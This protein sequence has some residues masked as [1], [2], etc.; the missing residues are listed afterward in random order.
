MFKSLAAVV[1]LCFLVPSAGMAATPFDAPAVF[2]LTGSSI[3]FSASVET[4][5]LGVRDLALSPNPAPVT[6]YLDID[7]LSS[8]TG[9]F[10][11]AVREVS[12][13]TT[14]T[15]PFD[16]KTFTIA[17]S[18]SGDS[19]S[20]IFL[21]KEDKAV[22]YPDTLVATFTVN[23]IAQS[24]PFT[25]IPLPAAYSDA[26]IRLSAQQSVEEEVYGYEVSVS[27]AI[28]LVG[29][30]DEQAN[31]ESQLWLA[32]QTS[33]DAC[34]SGDTLTLYASAGNPGEDRKLDFY[35][36][37]FDP[38]GNPFLAPEYI[39]RLAA[40]KSS[41]IFDGGAYASPTAVLEVKLPA[42]TPPMVTGGQYE[43]YGALIDSG[44]DNMAS[45][46]ASVQFTFDPDNES[47]E[48]P[49]KQYDGTWTGTGASDVATGDCPALAQV[50]MEIEQHEISGAGD[51]G[52]DGYE[53][54][55]SV[56]DGGEVVDG[57]LLEEFGPNWVP[58]GSFNGT[59]SGDTFS[60]RWLDNYGC[61]GS[62]SLTRFE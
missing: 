17:V 23:G 49:A 19:V 25:G 42:F 5:R 18:I 14:A 59:F 62:V 15:I 6:G 16:D 24:F 20:G 44:T 11:G 35:L 33:K 46:L 3:A 61:H 45:N 26:E 39:D 43:F 21:W 52:E 22:F 40:F 48:V 10:Y 53:L 4:Q 8:K 2:D 56:T 41:A 30:L 37:M 60:G 36:L 50:A 51:D 28:D 13:Q 58:V 57:V 32:L 7:Q 1:L 47:S 27:V 31:D 34:Y 29:V 55:G 54:T 38:S 12:A 9:I